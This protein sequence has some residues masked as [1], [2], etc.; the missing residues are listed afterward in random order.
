MLNATR[1]LKRPE[2]DVPAADPHFTFSG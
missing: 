1:E 2:V